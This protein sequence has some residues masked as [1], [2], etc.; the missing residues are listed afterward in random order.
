MSGTFCFDALLPPVTDPDC[1]LDISL[2][3]EFG[4]PGTVREALR[5]LLLVVECSGGKSANELR[6]PLSSSPLS[7]LP[8]AVDEDVGSAAELG[9]PSLPPPP[10]S[11]RELARTGVRAEGDMMGE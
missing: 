11:R 10:E 3:L 7:P 2:L 1:S 9:R 5:A 8:A 6:K 4:D